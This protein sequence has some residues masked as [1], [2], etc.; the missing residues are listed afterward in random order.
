MPAVAPPAGHA[1]PPSAER[2]KRLFRTQG[3]LAC[4]KH[5]DFPLGRS[6]QGPDLSRIGVKLRSP[7]GRLWLA[8][9]IRDPVRHSPRHADA[10]AFAGNRAGRRWRADWQSVQP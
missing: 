7:Q 1:E 5:R 10:Q 2:G 9:W 6:I 8:D 4:H 3:C